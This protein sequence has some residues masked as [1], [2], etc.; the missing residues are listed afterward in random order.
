MT[1]LMFCKLK[2]PEYQ[3]KN[4]LL[5]AILFCFSIFFEGR[6]RM[7]EIALWVLPRFFEMIWIGLKKKNL[8]EKPIPG[9]TYIL[10]ALSM[11]SLCWVYNNDKKSMKSK[12]ALLS[13]KILGD[14][15]KQCSVMLNELVGVGG[16]SAI[17]SSRLKK[18]RE[19]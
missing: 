5:T 15:P 2:T 10:Y 9:Y 16:D 19:N 14:E 11:A 6:G 4:F 1:K 7:E 18:L 8:V 13:K 12:Y 3:P 17:I